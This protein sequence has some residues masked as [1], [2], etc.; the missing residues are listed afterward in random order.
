[1]QSITCQSLQPKIFP[2]KILCYSRTWTAWKQ[3]LRADR[4]GQLLSS[5]AVF[6]TGM[7]NC[8]NNYTYMTCSYTVTMSSSGAVFPTGTYVQLLQ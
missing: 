1:M 4:Q 8:Y 2:T 7:F 3:H 5:D 6:P